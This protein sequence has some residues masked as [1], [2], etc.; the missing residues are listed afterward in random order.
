MKLTRYIIA[1]AVAIAAG[2]ILTACPSLQSE[3]TVFGIEIT[4]IDS[5][6]M[7]PTGRAGLIRHKNQLTQAG[8][9]QQFYNGESGVSLWKGSLDSAYTAMS[10]QALPDS[11]STNDTQARK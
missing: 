8:Q 4:A 6:T 9:A 2:L 1:V 3:T 5:S 10:C 7:M 11:A